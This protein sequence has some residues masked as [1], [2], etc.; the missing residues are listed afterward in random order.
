MIFCLKPYKNNSSEFKF[1]MTWTTDD[2]VDDTVD[3]ILDAF[4]KSDINEIIN[5]A[6]LN[7]RFINE[8]LLDYNYNI[9][10][11]TDMLKKYNS[12][13]TSSYIQSLIYYIKTERQELELFTTIK[14]TFKLYANLIQYLY[15]NYFKIL[16]PLN[17]N[18]L[19]LYRGF[20][21]N[22]YTKFML[23]KTKL[24]NINDEFN[25]G[26]FLS[27]SIYENTAYRFVYNDSGLI[28]NSIIWKI[29]TNNKFYYSYL[30]RDKHYFNDPLAVNQKEV[31]FLI[32]M[33]AKLKLINKYERNNKTYY[34]WQFIE[35]EILNND[36]FEQLN[37]YVNQIFDFIDLSIKK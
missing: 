18:E 34:E 35:Y 16:N 2:D 17:I 4:Q 33:N 12:K 27:T 7:Y 36:Y 24:L 22:K 11:I 15:Y 20:N 32:N 23:D 14:K 37:K 31:E 10:N 8:F 30:S 26:C 9:F 6:R 29:N 1:L 19:V 28:E 21:Y 3:N 13:I 5:I 25:T